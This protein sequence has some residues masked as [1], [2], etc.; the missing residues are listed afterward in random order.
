MLEHCLPH[1][2]GLGEPGAT[3]LPHAG[4]GCHLVQL[5][6]AIHSCLAT[7]LCALQVALGVTLV[8]IMA[9]QLLGLRIMARP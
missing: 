3:S 7:V 5:G 2:M 1:L 4:L 8:P 6:Q 9:N